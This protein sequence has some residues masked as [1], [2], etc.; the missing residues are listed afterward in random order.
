MTLTTNELLRKIMCSGMGIAYLNAALLRTEAR[1]KRTTLTSH[2]CRGT[3]RVDRFCDPEFIK[4]NAPIETAKN[5]VNVMRWT[6]CGAFLVG[7]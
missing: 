6:L 3:G 7:F 2:R 4:K 5:W 1:K